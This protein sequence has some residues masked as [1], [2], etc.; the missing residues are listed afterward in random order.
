MSKAIAAKTKTK[1][2]VKTVIPTIVAFVSLQFQLKKYFAFVWG[3]WGSVSIY[4]L[5]IVA[6][7]SSF[8][9]LQCLEPV[10]SGIFRPNLSNCDLRHSNRIDARPIVQC[11]FLAAQVSAQ[12]FLQQNAPQNL[13]SEPFWWRRTPC[14]S[15]GMFPT[16]RASG[17]LAVSYWNCMKTDHR[18]YKQRA[19]LFSP[20][21][22]TFLLRLP[23]TG[24]YN[25]G[26]WFFGSSPRKC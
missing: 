17:S 25:V 18:I 9:P 19:V 12:Q 11:R 4:V 20:A 7:L 16:V 2:T 8:A 1:K 13:V 6:N 5:N 26:Q 10:F 14:F 21:H 22:A 3:F 24:K 15:E 23:Y